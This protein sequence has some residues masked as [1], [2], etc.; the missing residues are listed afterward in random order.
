MS[1]KRRDHAIL[2]GKTPTFEDSA[3]KRSALHV[4]L[5]CLLITVAAAVLFA[6]DDH[7]I[8]STLVP[9]AI[10]TIHTDNDP[11][12]NTGVKISV[13][14]LANPHELS[15]GY[16]S[17]IVWIRPRDQQAV[18]AGELRV[19]DNLEGSLQTTTPNKDFDVFVTA[20]N[21]PRADTP[22]G[23]EVLHGTVSRH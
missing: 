7:M 15:P 11:N 8:N 18:N 13:H 17:Y 9:A 1:N 10:G 16:S 6:R 20:E 22:T 12:G 14:H 21:N 3:M 5:L 4:S 19:N 2:L 23:P